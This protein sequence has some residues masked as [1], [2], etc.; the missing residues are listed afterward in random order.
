MNNLVLREAL[1]GLLFFTII[2]LVL[3]YLGIFVS[4]VAIIYG[5]CVLAYAASFLFRL[6]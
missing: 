3:S 1:F 6:K 4:I 5:L 2:Y